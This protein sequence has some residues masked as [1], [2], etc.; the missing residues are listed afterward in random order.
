MSPLF[1]LESDLVG[2]LTPTLSGLFPDSGTLVFAPE[3]THHSRIVDLIV[4]DAGNPR[5][6]IPEWAAYGRAM[7]SLS[8]RQLSVLS[9]IWSEGPV[10]PDRLARLTWTTPDVLAREY[11]VPLVH[12]GLIDRRKSGVLQATEWAEWRVKTI[13]AIEAKL[14]D[15][16][17]V[18]EQAS[19]N[20][21]WADY[22]F[23]AMPGDGILRRD[24]VR[25]AVRDSR[26]GAISVHPDLG[27]SVVARP[28]RGAH[29]LRRRRSQFATGLLSELLNGDRWVSV[30]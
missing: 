13:V 16:R 22:S 12:A 9:I 25:A 30:A 11:V 8:K 29:T 19:D 5:D 6:S 17:N 28:R 4:C 7:R 24:D 3:V 20:A 1:E 15:W 14:S 23:I 10:A 18:V 27:A 21:L 26:V 2:V